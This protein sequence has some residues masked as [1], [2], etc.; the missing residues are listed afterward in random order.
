M[1][2]IMS[3]TT[4]G[5]KG[6]T[7]LE[8]PQNEQDLISNYRDLCLIKKSQFTVIQIKY[9]TLEPSFLFVFKAS[10]QMVTPT[11]MIEPSFLRN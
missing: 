1:F 8:L 3:W 7:S 4:E 11:L 2:E 9:Y 5:R 6:K 10:S